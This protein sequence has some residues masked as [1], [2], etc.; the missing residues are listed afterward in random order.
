[1]G[2]V[3]PAVGV[4]ALT[5][6]VTGGMFGGGL[7]GMGILGRVGA[8]RMG[9]R[10]ADQAELIARNGGALDRAPL[11]PNPLDKYAAWLAAAQQAKYLNGH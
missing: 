10:A 4:G 1:M 6:P 8:T 7:A 9:I 11:M 3:V 2:S 5:N